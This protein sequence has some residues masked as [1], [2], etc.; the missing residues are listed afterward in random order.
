MALARFGSAARGDDLYEAGTQ[1]GRLLRTLLLCDYLTNDAFRRELHRVLNRG[2]AAN[3]LKRAIYNGRVAN[4]QARHGD[5]MQ[6][7]AE[8]LNLL[9]NIIMTW[10]ALQ[11]QTALDRWSARRGMPIP[12]E[13]IGRIAPTRTEG[14]NLRGIFNFPIERYASQLVPS[15]TTEKRRFLAD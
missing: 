7:V 3:A 5:E 1:L 10:N 11:M 4:Y 6:A 9:A 14:I 2:E 8:A 15:L 13:L 12:Q